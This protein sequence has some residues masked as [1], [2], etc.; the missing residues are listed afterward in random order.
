MESKK[1]GALSKGRTN[2]G[3]ND[4][5]TRGDLLSHR[6]ITESLKRSF[7]YVTVRNLAICAV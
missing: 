1:L 7:K 6:A 2:E 3:A 5:L 4:P